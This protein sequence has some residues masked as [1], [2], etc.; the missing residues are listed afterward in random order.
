MDCLNQ[1]GYQEDIR[2]KSE[3]NAYHSYKLDICG[4]CNTVNVGF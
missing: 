2:F 1:N 3:K 4:I